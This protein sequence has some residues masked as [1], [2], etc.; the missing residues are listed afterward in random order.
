MSNVV[1]GGGSHAGLGRAR[2]SHSEDNG[3]GGAVDSVEVRRCDSAVAG[4]RRWWWQ[5]ACCVDAELRECF[6]GPA[7]GLADG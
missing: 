2:G 4:E 5:G 1:G 6:N 7:M 3:A